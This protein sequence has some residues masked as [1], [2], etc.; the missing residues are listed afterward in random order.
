MQDSNRP[1]KLLG[2]S[3]SLRAGANSEVV[4]QT[5]NSLLPPGVSFSMF[6]L[7]DVPLYNQDLD[8]TYK[9]AEAPKAVQALRDAISQADGLIIASPEYNYGMPG[10]L[11][12]ALD[13]ASRPV[14]ASPMKGKPVLIMSSSLGN[15]GGAR[16]QNSIRETLVAM[17]AR[18]LVRPDIAIPAVHQSIVDGLITD[19]TSL[20]FM[21][22]GV[23]DLVAEASR[24]LVAQAS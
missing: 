17:L 10:V 11:K 16:A 24:Q 22:Q 4:L 15:A 9:A 23:N 20:Q 6:R 21:R 19:A 18:P 7:H 14:F 2:L 3:G 5:A 1:L 13:W 12:N 8:D